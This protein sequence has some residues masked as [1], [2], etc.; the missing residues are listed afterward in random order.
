MFYIP[1]VSSELELI[2]GDPTTTNYRTIGGRTQKYDPGQPWVAV[3]SLTREVACEPQRSTAWAWPT[4]AS[5]WDQQAWTYQLLVL[6]QC[7]T[8]VPKGPHCYCDICHHCYSTIAVLFYPCLRTSKEGDQM[9]G[10]YCY[11]G[12]IASW[13]LP[14]LFD[15]SITIYMHMGNYNNG[16]HNWVFDSK[17]TNC[18]AI[19]FIIHITVDHAVSVTG[20]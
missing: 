3:D 2:Q 19:M 1:H 7:T 17:S 11:T 14:L 4:C 8:F 13:N 12:I 18:N 9:C 16:L 20:L 6:W 5:C 10:M 15:K